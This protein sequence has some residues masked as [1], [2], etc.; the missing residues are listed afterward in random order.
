MHPARPRPEITLIA[1]LAIRNRAIGSNG[2]LPWH[3]PE[4]LAR[5]KCLT[6]GHAVV[7][8][9]KTWQTD[10]KQRALPGRQ[11]IVLSARLADTQSDRD[12]LCFAASLP[13]AFDRVRGDRAFI[14]GGASIYAQTL[15][16]AD[17]LELTLV[18]DDYEGDT[19]FPDY[20]AVVARD[21]VL[22]SRE[23]WPQFE[24]VSYRRK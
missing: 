8:G 7:V 18:R 9:R 1:A 10:L 17:R 23:V 12:N 13:K 3:L 15:A 16:I 19:F 20:E 6:F 5:F 4:D 14:I 21:F 2:K 24:Y 22:E 11:T